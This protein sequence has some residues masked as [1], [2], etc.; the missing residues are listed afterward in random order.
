[1]KQKKKNINIKL[2]KNN[3]YIFNPLKKLCK[4]IRLEISYG[5]N[6]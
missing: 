6:L 4:C 5:M 2:N 3:E 1:M